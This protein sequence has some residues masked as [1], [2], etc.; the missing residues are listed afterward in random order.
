[1]T[2]ATKALACA[3]WKAAP[4]AARKKVTAKRENGGVCSVSYANYIVSDNW[5]G[6]LTHTRNTCERSCMNAPSM[7]TPPLP[8]L[9]RERPE[10]RAATA[11]PAKAEAKRMAMEP[12]AMS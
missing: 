8:N 6:W 7:S 2:V 9:A 10:T 1:M 12:V 11:Q 5:R 4:R 3:S